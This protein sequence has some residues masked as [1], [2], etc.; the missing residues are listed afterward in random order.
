MGMVFDGID[1]R[2]VHPSQCGLDF[3]SKLYTRSDFSTVSSQNPIVSFAL[4]LSLSRRCSSHAQQHATSVMNPCLLARSLAC[5]LVSLAHEFPRVPSDDV[6]SHYFF[7]IIGREI[8]M[9]SLR[10]IPSN[11]EK[12]IICLQCC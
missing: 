12:E 8:T 5:P 11:L 4:S 7:S 6:D 3:F 9:G 10:R 2:R 1:R